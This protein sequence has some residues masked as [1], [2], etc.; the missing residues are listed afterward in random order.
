MKGADSKLAMLNSATNNALILLRGQPEPGTLI[1]PETGFFISEQDPDDS[2]SDQIS[3][4]YTHLNNIILVINQHGTLINN[5]LQ[6]QRN[7][8]DGRQIIDSLR[9]IDDPTDD[10]EAGSALQGLKQKL[11]DMNKG[12]LQNDTLTAEVGQIVKKLEEKTVELELSKATYSATDNKVSD[13]EDRISKKI[14]ELERRVTEQLF[15]STSKNS[16]SVSNMVEK[17]NK[18]EKELAWKINDCT[19]LLKLRPSEAVIES[20]LTSLEQKLRAEM[21]E[22]IGKKIS[23]AGVTR[24][25]ITEEETHTTSTT[26]RSTTSFNDIYEKMHLFENQ[27]SSITQTGDSA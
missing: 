20:N 23:D 11:G 10:S 25:R 14:T 8:V 13:A 7:M 21:D 6:S 18:I 15:E 17:M 5:V 27:Y 1:N 4:V 2:I 3:T 26:A 12:L 24:T 9:R 19:D 16:N 22:I